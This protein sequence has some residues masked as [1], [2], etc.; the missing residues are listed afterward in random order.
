MTKTRQF[1]ISK[2]MIYHTIESQA[3]SIEKAILECLMNAVDANASKV[4]VF[5]DNNGI[6]YTISD[7]GKGFKTEEEIYECFEVFGFDHGTPEENKRT[8]GTFGIGRAQLW[9]FSK[10]QW[11]TNEFVLEVD[12][13]NK[14]LD[15]K[16]KKEKKKFNGCKIV[17]QFYEKQSLIELQNIKREL[18]KLAKYLPID[19]TINDEK[20]NKDIKSEKWDFDNEDSLVKLKKTGDLIIYNKGVFVCAYPNW[21]YGTGGTI[22]S[23]NSLTLNTA[24]NDILLAKCSVWKKIKKFLENESTSKNLKSKSLT[25]EQKNNLVYQFLYG[26]LTYSDIAKKKIFIDIKGKGQTIEYIYN[27]FN[28]QVT[29]ADNRGSQKG[30]TILN[31]K[32]AFVFSPQILEFLNMNSEEF[33]ENI[34]KRVKSFYSYRKDL[35]F[36]DFSNLK[37]NISDFSL[38]IEPRKYTKH[39]KVEM[40]V[41]NMINNG[42][43]WSLKKTIS[44]VNQKRTLVLVEM[45]DSVLA[46]TDGKRTISINKNFLKSE[47]KRGTRGILKVIMVLIHEYC[48]C[49]NSNEDHVHSHE[50]YENFHDYIV[51]KADIIDDISKEALMYYVKYLQKEG[52]SINK[53]IS[54]SFE[55]LDKNVA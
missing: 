32:V 14:G 13:K 6:D 25:D 23:K 44:D 18:E 9:A 41:L 37:K 4:S 47:F 39:Q 15:Y 52:L 36:V 24:R 1:K 42:L 31:T 17:G 26:D 27:N 5:L 21:K 49:I 2:N 45:D 7:N 19:F 28:Y 3:G 43:I 20:V 34:N 53:T 48:H 46:Y 50:F 51:S 54:N 12:I 11:N 40:K 35:S 16:L 55:K 22:V 33:I 10:N 29:V 38:T 30:E 8:Y